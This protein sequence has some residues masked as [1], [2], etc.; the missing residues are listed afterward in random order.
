MHSD[1]RSSP[2]GFLKKKS[3]FLIFLLLHTKQ[4][5]NS[6][7]QRLTKFNGLKLIFCYFLLLHTQQTL[8][9][10]DQ[11]LTKFEVKINFLLYIFCYYTPSRP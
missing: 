3:D 5:L 11:R 4:T 10:Q 6:Q 2:A 9:S 8:N 1:S 7:G